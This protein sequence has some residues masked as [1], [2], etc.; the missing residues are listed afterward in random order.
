MID[1][2][3]ARNALDPDEWEHHT[4]ENVCEFLVSQFDRFPDTARIYHNQV[5]EAH[6]VTPRD[7]ASIDRLQ[8]LEGTLYVVVYPADPVTVIVAIV[9][10]VAVA[11]VVM[12]ATAPPTP[13]LRNTQR[14]SPNNELAERTNRPRPQAR[15]PDIFGTVRS[16]PDLIGVPYNEFIN[17]QEIEHAYMCIGRGEYVISDI[18]D[19]TTP[20]TDIAGASVEIYGPGTSPNSGDSPIMTVGD[21]IAREVYSITRS[22]AVNGQVLRPPNSASIVGS[23]NI[24]F[25]SPNVISGTGVD[26]TNSFE[27]GDAITIA[28]TTVTTNEYVDYQTIYASDSGWFQFEIPSATLPV[29]YQVG[30]S[31]ELIGATFSIKDV[32]GFVIGTYE[33]NG[34]YTISNVQSILDGSTYY[35][36]VTLNNPALINAD[37]SQADAT[38]PDAATI[39]VYGQ[40]AQFDLDG[41][42]TVLSVSATTITLSNPAAV[43]PNWSALSTITP[44]NPYLSTSGSKWI[45]PFIMD[46]DD[47]TRVSAN[48]VALNGLYKDDGKN[49]VRFDVQLSLEITPINAD[50]SDR[51]V[52]QTEYVTIQGSS[53]TTSTRAVTLDVAIDDPGLIKVR[54]RRVTNADLAFEGSVVDE[55]KWRDVFTK[56]PIGVTEFGDVTTV[57]SITYATAG[58]LALKERKLNMLVTRKIPLRNPGTDTFTTTLYATN[59]AEEIFAAVCLDPFIGNRT[60]A[61]LDLDNIYS[62]V[63]AVRTYFGDDQAAEFCYTF[64]AENLSFEETAQAIA[65]AVYCM[66]YRRG[67]RIYVN[68]EQ[69]TDSSLLLFNH[70]NKIPDSETRTIRFGRNNNHDGVEYVYVDPNDDSIS[71]YYIPSDNSA[72]N[73]Q[74]VESIGVRSR[75]QAHFHAWRTWNKIRYQNVV[76]EFQATQE[77]DLLVI[78]DRILVAD[79]TRTGTQDGEVLEQNALELTL[80]QPV[81][82]TTGVNYTIF[83]Q[84]YDGTVESMAVSSGSDRYKVILAQAPRLPLVTDANNYARATYIVVGDTDSAVNAFILTEKDPGS[85]FTYTVR[86]VNYDMRYYAQDKDYIDGL[87]NAD[88]LPIT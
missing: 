88:G 17:H 54:A 74:K 44:A 64:D 12:M 38:V 84:H 71:T 41:S 43:N 45:G 56:S 53:T 32:D 51:G 59:K 42:Y 15:I 69:E 20:L 83:L 52:V 21:P 80:S 2:I 40:I 57:Q 63:A 49:Q 29:E 13:T 27:A 65:N 6:D 47:A 58:A 66:A 50:G 10:V 62:T 23:Y 8:E 5:S 30:R 14:E 82:F 70:R 61:E 48:F 75:L 31:V 60:V 87:V 39:V 55:V 34:T 22:N 76:T 19:D 1:V 7:Q 3:L 78:N 81:L 36:R 73:P 79:N 77:A 9:A 33:L 26:F 35:C 72:K 46:T 68:F 85:N 16:T 67:S 37:W 11:A 86:A 4:V 24:T 18:R 25:S 28:N